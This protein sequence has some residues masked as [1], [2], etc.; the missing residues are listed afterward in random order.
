M[1]V[2]MLSVM[3]WHLL[4]LGKEQDGET[5]ERQVEFLNTVTLVSIEIFVYAYRAWAGY[6]LMLNGFMLSLTI[7]IVFMMC[8]MSWHLLSLGIELN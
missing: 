6:V 4:S 1:I 3:S 2:F 7:M 8:V 5:R